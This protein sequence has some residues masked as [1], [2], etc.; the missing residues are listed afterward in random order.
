MI[1]TVTRTHKSQDGIFGN[2]SVDVDPFK[3]V[4]LENLGLCIPTGTYDVLFMWSDH[5]QQIMP[6]VMVPNRTAIEIH[7]ANFPNQL[8]G[9]LALGTQDDFAHDAIM[10][11]KDM[12]IEFV[13]T[14]SDQPSIK[15]K[16]VED[17]GT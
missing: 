9:C 3:C 8:E 12:W 10:Q 2:L 14:I 4:T 5:F 6:H 15:I 7:W 13:K 1:I 17:Y 16:Y 11:S